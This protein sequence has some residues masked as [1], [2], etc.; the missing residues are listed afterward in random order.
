MWLGM[1]LVCQ[2]AENKAVPSTLCV[3]KPDASWLA[4]KR[5]TEVGRA[6]RCS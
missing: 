1:G 3:R 5:N 4:G 2:D 6:H